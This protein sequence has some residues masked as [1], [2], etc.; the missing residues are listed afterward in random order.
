MQADRTDTKMLLV[1][2]GLLYLRVA[3][4]LLV[5]AVH[6]LPKVLHYSSQAAVIEDPFHLGK[7][8]SLSFAIFAEVVCP[9]L[10]ILGIATRLAAIPILLVTVIALAFV[11][12]EWTLEQGQ[13]AWM[14]LILFGTIAIAGPGQ[15]RL[16]KWGEPVT[17]RR[18]G[19]R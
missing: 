4:S 19:K 6:G 18:W 12:R 17:T 3:A 10:M 7:T 5:L 14:L 8:L 1:D 11:H 9:P 15:Y 13:F 16:G 2:I